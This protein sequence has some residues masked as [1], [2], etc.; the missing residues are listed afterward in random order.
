LQPGKPIPGGLSNA[1]LA[2]FC[3]EQGINLVVCGP[4]GPLAEGL[5][6]QFRG[7]P[8]KF[9][10][11]SQAAAQLES[12]KAFAKEVLAKAEIPTAAFE[13]VSD[14]GELAG[15]ANAFFA[16]HGG[17]VIKA[18]GLAAGKGVFVCTTKDAITPA[19]SRLSKDMREAASTVVLE[20]VLAGRECSYFVAIGPQSRTSLGFAVDHKRLKDGD[21]GPNTGGM[22]CYTPVPWLPANAAET[23]ERVV[24]E[25]LLSTLKAMAIPYVGFLYVGLMWG[26]GGPQ[27]VE[28][29]CRLGDP[30]AQVLA[31]TDTSDWLR[32]IVD[33][34]EGRE[35]QPSSAVAGAAV[36]VVLAAD[37]YP[38]DPPKVKPAHFAAQDL[39]AQIDSI[40][41]GASVTGS[42]SEVVTG[43]GRVFCVVGAGEGLSIAR[44]AA[45]R[46]VEKIVEQ[47]PTCQYRSDIAGSL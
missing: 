35:P 32:M 46:R 7:H 8:T 37:G 43:K 38:Y 5:A 15:R 33:L 1:A 17:V 9:F 31:L 39:D 11:P 28:F 26:K 19:V 13:V 24:V 21:E 2:E 22:G 12:S 14:L 40:V 18:S 27:V 41:F 42:D 44:A 20:S 45:Y 6:D 34:L 30:E 16:K 10:G 23:V 4:E 25:P 29:N 36:G 3:A 47:W